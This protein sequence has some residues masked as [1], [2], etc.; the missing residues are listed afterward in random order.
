MQIIEY[1]QSV[2][3][4]F[5]TSTIVISRRSFTYSDIIEMKPFL[6][7]LAKYPTPGSYFLSFC[8]TNKSLTL[9]TFPSSLCCLL[10]LFLLLKAVVEED[11]MA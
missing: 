10:F 5:V 3:L 11:A 9:I 1:L 4:P 2:D 8:L 6:A 7:R